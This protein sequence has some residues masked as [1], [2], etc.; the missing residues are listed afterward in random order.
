[1]EDTS[2]AINPGIISF[3]PDQ[4]PKKKRCRPRKKKSTLVLKGAN[5]IPGRVCRHLLNHC[6]KRFP[7]KRDYKTY[8][9][10]LKI[11]NRK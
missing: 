5:V 4:P 9:A 11:N 10:T 2:V 3:S 6:T 1:M 8:N 7:S